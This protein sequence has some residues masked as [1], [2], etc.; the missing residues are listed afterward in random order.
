MG[1]PKDNYAWIPV[2]MGIINSI[3]TPYAIF[4]HLGVI[5]VIPW[6]PHVDIVNVARML[7]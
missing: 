1:Q 4:V 2:Q 3:D 5:Y 6:Q 7:F